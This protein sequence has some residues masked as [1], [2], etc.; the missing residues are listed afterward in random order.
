MVNNYNAF[1]SHAWDH[2]DDLVNLRILLSAR[3]Y[4]NIEYKE[5]SRDEPINSPNAVYIKR[6]LK[7]KIAS[8]H[9][10]LGLAGIY[11]SHSDWMEWELDTAVELG[12]PIIG[13][14][15]LGQER[16]SQTIAKRSIEIVR[17]NTESIVS[18]IR[19]NAKL[20]ID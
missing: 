18:S 15:P 13:I 1:I 9:I 11:A 17:W 7:E 16:I 3:G 20:L 8:S 10:V 6:R 4:F 2:H 19:H 12:I 14:A 5:V